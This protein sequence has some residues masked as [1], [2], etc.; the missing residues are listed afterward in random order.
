MVANEEPFDFEAWLKCRR[1]VPTPE[2]LRAVA[3][4]T[5]MWNLFEAQLFPDTKPDKRANI[6]GLKELARRVRYSDEHTHVLA[7]CVDYY[8]SRYLSEG[9]F[10]DLFEGLKFRKYEN[11]KKA[12]ALVKSVLEGENESPSDQMFAMLVIV[13]RIR[14]N[15]FHGLK[16]VDK[17]DDQAS[18]I[19]HA[20]KVL[21]LALET[22]RDVYDVYI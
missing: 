6:T 19:S 21:A 3:G 8:Q 15:T 20:A 17:W 4:F 5:L 13:Y 9:A 7:E 22:A 18:N 12:R 2:A 1:D 16:P 14:N 10:N 11:E